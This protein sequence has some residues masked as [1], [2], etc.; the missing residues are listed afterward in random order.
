MLI[1]ISSIYYVPGSELV[2]Y[3]C[4]SLTCRYSCPHYTDKANAQRVEP[5]FEATLFLTTLILPLNLND[6]FLPFDNSINNV[7]LKNI[8]HNSLFLLKTNIKNWFKSWF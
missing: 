5:G 7:S 8:F 4:L 6:W 1:I 3:K 2:L